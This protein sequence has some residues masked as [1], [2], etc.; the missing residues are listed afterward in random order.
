MFSIQ[1]RYPEDPIYFCALPFKLCSPGVPGA[2]G[3]D[4]KNTQEAS[5]AYEHTFS[6]SVEMEKNFM[7]K[8]TEE[9]FP[10]KRCHC[11]G[12]SFTQ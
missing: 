3:D 5:A 4:L 11:L 8:I 7:V 9:V 10:T 1:F 6:R 2:D 12:H